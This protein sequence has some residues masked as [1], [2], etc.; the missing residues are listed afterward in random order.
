[1]DELVDLMIEADESL[2]ALLPTVADVEK[3]L[4]IESSGAGGGAAS[5]ATS[6]HAVASTTTTTSPSNSSRQQSPVSTQQGTTV[7]LVEAVAR[8]G[9]LFKQS[10]AFHKVIAAEFAWRRRFTKLLFCLCFRR[11]NSRCKRDSLCS[12]RTICF[13]RKPVRTDAHGAPSE[14]A[15]VWSFVCRGERTTRFVESMSFFS[16]LIVFFSFTLI[17]QTT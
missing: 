2:L 16:L 1:M 17:R 5:G 8:Q 4:N 10:P 7:D 12:S 6:D 13:I 15:N 11:L 3:A 9:W 14:Y